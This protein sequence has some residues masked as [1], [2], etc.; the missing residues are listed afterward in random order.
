M[1]NDIVFDYDIGRPTD[2]GRFRRDGL[3][4]HF[5]ERVPADAHVPDGPLD[6]NSVPPDVAER[7]VFNSDSVGPRL[8]GMGG[9]QESHT[10]APRVD[11]LNAINGDTRGRDNA[12]GMA[13][14]I[15]VEYFR[16]IAVYG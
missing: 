11:E 2:S 8:A 13:L 4:A 15:R 16:P 6:G 9:S 5:S 1:V 3:I 7:R 14:L 12:E 10:I